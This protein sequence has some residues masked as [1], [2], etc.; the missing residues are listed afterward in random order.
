[1]NPKERFFEVVEGLLI[2]LLVFFVA[3][4]RRLFQI[5]RRCVIDCRFRTVQINIKRHKRAILL[6]KRRNRFL[7]QEFVFPF[8]NVHNDFRAVFR[9]IAFRQSV[10]I[11]AVGLPSNR[12]RVLIAF[13]DNLHPIGNHIRRIKT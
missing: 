7:L 5:Q 13:R 6:Q 4:L 12:R 1:M 10:G 9:F 2:E 11:F 8:R 3:T